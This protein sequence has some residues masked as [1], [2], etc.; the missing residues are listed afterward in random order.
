MGP[1]TRS[2]DSQSSH[3]RLGPRTSGHVL[4]SSHPGLPVPFALSPQGL[5]VVEGSGAGPW[6]LHSLEPAM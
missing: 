1:R 4:Q 2:Y 5:L 3:G 6:E